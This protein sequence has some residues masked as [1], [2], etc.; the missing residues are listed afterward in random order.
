[1]GMAR[2]GG[3]LLVLCAVLASALSACGKGSDGASPLDPR[4]GEYKGPP[5]P[6]LS[7]NTLAELQKRAKYQ[8]FYNHGG[9]K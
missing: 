8:E 2:R 6:Q 9:P 5:V 3:V 4:P 7:S 1:M